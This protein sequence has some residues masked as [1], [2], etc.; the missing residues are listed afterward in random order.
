[1]T[2]CAFLMF[3]LPARTFAGVRRSPPFRPTAT[4]QASLV[5]LP[6]RINLSEMLVDVNTYF[7]GRKH[8]TVTSIYGTVF[9]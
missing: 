6:M 1:M 4:R 8:L 3:A 7:Q 5:L 2:A 9:A